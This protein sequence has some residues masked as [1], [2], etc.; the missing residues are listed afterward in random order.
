MM[1]HGTGQTLTRAFAAFAA[2]SFIGADGCAFDDD[3]SLGNDDPGAG[4]AG[5]AATAGV[6]GTSS[7]SGGSGGTAR[8]GAAS[9][10][11]GTN[12]P[13]GSG[14]TDHGEGGTPASPGDAG[15]GNSAAMGGSV[16]AGSGGSGNVGEAGRNDDGAGGRADAPTPPSCEAF[17]GQECAGGDCCES[18]RVPGGTVLVNG[19]EWTIGDFG[20]D[21][22][23]VTVGR[24]QRYMHAIEAWAAAGNPQDGA[25]AYPGVPESGY[26]RDWIGDTPEW[27]AAGLVPRWLGYPEW[28]GTSETGIA[29][30]NPN[31][32]IE[33][34]EALAVNWVPFHIAF[35]FCIWDGGRLPIKAEWLHVIRGAGAQTAY[36]WGNTPALAEMFASLPAASVPTPY[37][38]RWWQYIGIPVGSHPAS[39]GNLGHH[40][41]AAGFHEF[42]RDTVPLPND[43]KTGGL[44]ELGTDEFIGTPDAGSNLTFNRAASSGAW[45]RLDLSVAGMSADGTGRLGFRCA[46]EAP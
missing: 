27:I 14:G 41:L 38:D 20:L 22:F 31:Y 19:T 24:F 42:L 3:V 44:I 43:P 25:G 46:R 6:G 11:G 35:A 18:I 9:A 5:S 36:P 8:G 15:A 2:L 39:V 34:T 33:G 12:T 13:P 17:R 21:K 7:S 23:E 40:D 30:G 10:S 29:G 16:S 1:D 28:A 4:E 26:R 37:D 45:D 32:V